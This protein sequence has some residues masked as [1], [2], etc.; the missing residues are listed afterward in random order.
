MVWK[1]SARYNLVVFLIAYNAGCSIILA[2][3]QRTGIQSM[4][5]VYYTGL[6]TRP[7]PSKR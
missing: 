3:C 1:A 5:I 2:E 7:D 6:R 4:S